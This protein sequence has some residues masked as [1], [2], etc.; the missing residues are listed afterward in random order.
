LSSSET[1]CK[2]SPKLTSAAFVGM[3]NLVLAFQRENPKEEGK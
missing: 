3:E 1:A 2:F